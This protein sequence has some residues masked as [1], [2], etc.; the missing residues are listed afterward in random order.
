[1]IFLISFETKVRH[2][3]PNTLKSYSIWVRK[4]QYFSKSKEPELLS[5]SDVKEFLTFLAVK[6]KVSA[7]SQNQAFN[8]LLFFFRHV[9]NREFG[10][11][12]GVV[13]AK[14]K[15]HIPVVL[16]REEIDAIMTNLKYPDGRVT[17]CRDY[18]DYVCGN[19]N[20]QDFYDIWHGDKYK[21]FRKKLKKGLMPVCTRCCGLQG[22]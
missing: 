18:Q 2:Y 9:L 13:R 4:F 20:D 3:S 15:P 12:D 16:S 1:M 21:E 11:I 5:A 22:F 7:S 8:A 14:R 6:Q 19:V 17:P 10:K